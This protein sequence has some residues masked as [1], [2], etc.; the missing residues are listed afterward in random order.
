MENVWDIL[1]CGIEKMNSLVQSL[2][3]LEVALHQEWQQLHLDY[4]WW[5]IQGMRRRVAAVIHSMV[6]RHMID[7]LETF[8]L[9]THHGRSLLA[10]LEPYIKGMLPLA[11]F[12]SQHIFWM[13]SF[14]NEI[15][16]KTSEYVSSFVEYVYSSFFFS[17]QE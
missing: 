4:C 2:A 6:F 3:Q 12:S 10:G 1:G 13:S 14:C 17:L 8:I 15:I 9:L 16:N 11:P 5:L 7:I